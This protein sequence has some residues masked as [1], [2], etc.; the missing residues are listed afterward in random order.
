MDYNEF[1]DSKQHEVHHPQTE[2]PNAHGRATIILCG[3]L[4]ADVPVL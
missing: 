4:R 3:V 2:I 1:L